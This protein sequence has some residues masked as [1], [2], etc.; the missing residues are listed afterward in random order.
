MEARNELHPKRLSGRYRRLS[1]SLFII[2]LSIYTDTD[3]GTETDTG[4][5]YRINS[6]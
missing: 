3:T 1:P 6:K 4:L 5:A 2:C